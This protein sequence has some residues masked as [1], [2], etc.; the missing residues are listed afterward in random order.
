[1]VR[2]MMSGIESEWLRLHPGTGERRQI[3]IVDDIARNPQKT[4][5]PGPLEMSLFWPFHIQAFRS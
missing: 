4:D 1:M 2:Q 3:G 5:P